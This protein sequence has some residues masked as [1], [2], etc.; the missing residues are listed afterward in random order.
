MKKISYLPPFLVALI[1]ALG[2]GLAVQRPASA[3]VAANTADP[4]AAATGSITGKVVDSSGNPVGGAMIRL[5]MLPKW[6]AGGK[7]HHHKRPPQPQPG[8]TIWHHMTFGVTRTADDGTFTVN[9][10]P[11]GTYRIMA[12]DRHVGFGRTR[13]PITVSV[14]QDASAGT[15]TLHQ[16]RHMR[17]GPPH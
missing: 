3:Q 17:H 6:M 14:G 7:G 8:Q 2:V 9:N 10:A 13:R 4:N 5:M 11:V 12:M 15:I 16:G 1:L